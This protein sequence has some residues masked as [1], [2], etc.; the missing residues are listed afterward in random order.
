MLTGSIPQ[1]LLWAEEKKVIPRRYSDQVVVVQI[2]PDDD[3]PQNCQRLHLQYTQTTDNILPA[4]CR[5]IQAFWRSTAPHGN[6]VTAG[7]AFLGVSH[8]YQ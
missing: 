6:S 4:C 3:L 1:G 5:K 2:C 7:Q 8:S